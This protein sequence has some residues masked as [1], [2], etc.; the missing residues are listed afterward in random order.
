MRLLPVVAHITI[1]LQNNQDNGKNLPLI[2]QNSTR[3]DDFLENF[4]FWRQKWNRPSAGG[5]VEG[6][7]G[8]RKKRKRE[9]RCQGV[10]SLTMHMIP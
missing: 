6:R 9:E 7:F 2:L 3:I 5:P 1:I 4:S 8:E 10:S